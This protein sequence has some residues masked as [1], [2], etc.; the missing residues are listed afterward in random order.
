MKTRTVLRSLMACRGCGSVFMGVVNSGNPSQFCSDRCRERNRPWRPND[1]G[2][3]RRCGEKSGLSKFCSP[4]LS[5]RAQ[6][7][8]VAAKARKA[9][10]RLAVVANR[11]R[12]CQQC[13]ALFTSKSALALYCSGVCKGRHHHPIAQWEGRE[14]VECGASFLPRSK[15][16]THCTSRCTKRPSKIHAKRIAKWRTLIGERDNWTCYLC[17]TPIRLDVGAPHPLAYSVDHVV[18]LSAGGRDALDNLRCA[19]LRCNIEK[20]DDLIWVA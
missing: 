20:A 7:R 8:A 10:K 13:G 15:S 2:R 14:C 9:A 11:T 5:A 16:H 3:C 17:S 1:R 18:P 19:H 4:C 12:P 6:E